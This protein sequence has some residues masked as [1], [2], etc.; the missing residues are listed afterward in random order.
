M[1][2]GASTTRTHIGVAQDD[3][4]TV[5]GFVPIRMAHAGTAKVT[6][7]AAISAGAL[8][9]YDANGRIGTTSASNTAVGIALEAASGAGSVIEVMMF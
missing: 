3:Q 9:F 7:N 6:A 8:V 5:G 1:Q 2:N 4:A